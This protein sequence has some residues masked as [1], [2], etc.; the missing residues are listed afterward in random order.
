MFISLLLNKS[1]IIS[2]FLR[3]TAKCN[4]VLWILLINFIRKF[5]VFLKFLVWLF[6]KRNKIKKL[7]VIEKKL[8][9][10][11][12]KKISFLNFIEII[13]FELCQKNDN[14]NMIEIIKLELN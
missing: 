14:F 2:M 4:G 9:E 3:L 13:M 1:L 5:L 12:K 10:C 8:I 11:Y 6:Y 7:N